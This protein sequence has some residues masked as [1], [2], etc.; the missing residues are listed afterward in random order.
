MIDSTARI[1]GNPQ[2]ADDARVD[3]F[4][5]LTGSVIVGKRVHVGTGSRL[6]G[7]SGTILLKPFSGI[8]MGVTLLSASDN[9]TSG[10]AIGPCFDDDLRK[11]KVGDVTLEEF[12]VVGAHSVVMPGVRLGWGAALGACSFLTRDI[13]PGEVWFGCPAKRVSFRDLDRLREVAEQ[14]EL[15]YGDS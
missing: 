4:C 6:L 14:A 15:R 3:A 2:I 9:Y 5:V 13:P 1:F 12:A 10:H 8:S 7:G 11:V